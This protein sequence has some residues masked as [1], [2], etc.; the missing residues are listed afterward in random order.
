MASGNQVCSGNW[1]LLPMQAQNR[2]TPAHSSTVWLASPESA[3][4][5]M[6]WMLKP[7]APRFSW[8]QELAPKNRIAV[9][10][11]R[12]T[13]P[14]R[15]VKNAFSAALAL[16]SSSHQC[17]ISMNEQRPMISQ[18]RI[19]WTMFSAQDHH[20]HAGGE[21]RDGGEEVGVAAVAADVLQ[22]EDLHE[23]RDE[24]DEEQQ[25]HRQAV[26]LLADAELDAAALPPRPLADHRLDV[27]LGVAALAGGDAAGEAGGD[28]ERP[29]RLG[30]GGGV[31]AL[32]PLVRRCR[33][34]ARAAAAIEARPSSEPFIGRRLPNRMMR[35]KATPGMSG[36]SQAFSRNHPVGRSAA[37]T[38]SPSSR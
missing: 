34:R 13:S 6:P 1:P 33:R 3:Q 29:G 38:L 8:A 37:S 15:T 25:H 22:R 20:E 36:I 19:S 30:A 26:D 24:G 18:P 10:T 23:Q 5:E 35:K 9:P 2:A 14:T 28:A 31:G 17:P 11:S 7:L 27:R 16:G 32:D 4:P 12:P 21:Q